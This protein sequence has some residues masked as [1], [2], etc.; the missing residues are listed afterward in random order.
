MGTQE[1]TRKNSILQTLTYLVFSR[2]SESLL[3]SLESIKAIAELT[4]NSNK[5]S[6]RK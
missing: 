6:E 1:L 4:A 3:S 2:S 5:G